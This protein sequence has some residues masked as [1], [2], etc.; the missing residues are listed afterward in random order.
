[1][2]LSNCNGCPEPYAYEDQKHLQGYALAPR[3]EPHVWR[4]V[5]RL[6]SKLSLKSNFESQ[7]VC[8]NEWLSNHLLL[9]FCFLKNRARFLNEKKHEEKM[10]RLAFE[11]FDKDNSGYI[12]SD[13]FVA[14]MS[15]LGD[16]LTEQEVA[17]FLKHFDVDSDG[18]V[19]DV[20]PFSCSF[21]NAG[22]RDLARSILN[23]S[24]SPF[25]SSTTTYTLQIQYSEFLKAIQSQE[26]KVNSIL[27][28]NSEDSEDSTLEE[29]LQTNQI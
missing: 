15:E 9:N 21:V 8:V 1:M 6:V 14:A 29:L 23:Q 10:I 7:S 27:K 26:E 12:T 25:H 24:F 22:P 19:S 16:P 11:Y 28:V 5:P 17:T 2:C 18:K 3:K 20:V 13:E 4:V